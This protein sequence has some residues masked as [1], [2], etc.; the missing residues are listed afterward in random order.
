MSRKKL[1]RAKTL[2]LYCVTMSDAVPDTY[3]VGAS[4]S[5]SPTIHSLDVDAMKCHNF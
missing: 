2:L 1:C 4:D 5:M 3:G